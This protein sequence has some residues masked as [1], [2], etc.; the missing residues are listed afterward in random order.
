V[1]YINESEINKKIE[2]TIVSSHK[3]IKFYLESNTTFIV[4]STKLYE[5]ILA[6]ILALI[7]RYDKTHVII[8]IDNQATIRAIENPRNNLRQHL[9]KNID[10]F[11]NLLRKK[12]IE[13]ELH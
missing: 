9:I 10:K 1:I 13:I 6:S 7:L 5:I 11:I 2:A 3:T 12:G 8:C 4:Y